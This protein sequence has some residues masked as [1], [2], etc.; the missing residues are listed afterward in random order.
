[1]DTSEKTPSEKKG[2]IN[3]ILNAIERIGNKLPDPAILFFLLMLVIWVL[4]A[5]FSPYDF[6]EIDP[7]TGSPIQ[8]NNLLTS[9]ALAEFLSGMV[10][11]FTSFA[12]LG[13]VLVAMLGVGVAEHSGF[14]NAGLKSMLQITPK[15]LLTPMLILVAIV[16]HTATDA[17]YVLVIPLG[18]VIFY[19]AGR[20]PIAGIAAAFAGVSGGFSANFVPSGIDPLLQGFTQSAAQLM[21]PNIQVNPLNNWYFTSAS[22]VLIVLV[23][24]YITDKIVEPRLKKVPVEVDDEEE[25]TMGAL[26]PKEKNSF[27]WA[28]GVMILSL[29]GLFFWAAPVDSALR[30]AEGEITSF[31]A[32]LMQSIVPLIFI[33]FLIPG[34][35]YGFAAKTYQSSQDVI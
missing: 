7:T 15:K 8:I 17:G 2:F 21:D 28:C 4:S 3:K 23:G 32:P 16:S 13:I 33:I 6:S 24:W 35:V 34:V 20:H 31:A 18:G 10:T 25:T 30:D 27:Y 19:A 22:S 12:P 14:I 5:I 1:M 9:T 29:I 26:T 11:T